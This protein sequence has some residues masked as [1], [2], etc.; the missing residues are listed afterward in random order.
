MKTAFL[1][2]DEFGKYSYGSS[3]PMMPVRLIITYEL[4]KSYGLLNTPDTRL[5]D[6]RKATEAELLCFHT[7]EY[8]KTLK[9]ADSGDMPENGW[10]HGL[11]FGDNPVFKGVYA[12]SLYSAGASLQAAEL[13][14]SGKTDIAF[15]I[16]GG[17]HHAMADKA[18]GFCYLNDAVLAIKYLL[19][20]GKRIAY[21]DIDAHHGDGVQAAFYDTDRVLTISLHESGHYL[22]PGTGFPNEAGVG[23]GKGYSVNLPLPPEADDVVF[24]K[25]FKDIVPLFIDRFK[26]DIIVTQLGVDTFR[27]DPITHLNLTTNG[28]EILINY[29]KSCGL[30]WIALGG[31]GYNLDNVA[32]AWTLAWTVM[33]GVKLQNKIPHEFAHMAEKFGVSRNSVVDEPFGL[34]AEKREQ[35][36]ESMQ[37]DIAFLKKDVLPL[38]K[39]GNR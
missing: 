20:R 11:G 25:S 24:T 17:L 6:A 26:P 29:F 7:K 36:L 23:K 12:W 19:T 28:F 39:T 37:G 3:H 31:G 22:F 27:T 32:R 13:V 5:I 21:V 30:P 1:Y 35:L 8:I 16:C 14:S 33:N 38:I 34:A 10:R 9:Q 18:S 15:N 2:S 4:I